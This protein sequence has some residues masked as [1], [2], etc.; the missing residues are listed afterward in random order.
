[1]FPDIKI[2]D[3]VGDPISTAGVDLSHPSSLLNYLKTELLHLAVLPDFL[4][5]KDLKLTDAATK[6]IEFKADVKD[7]FQLGNTKPE[8]NVTPEVQASIRVNATPGSELVEDDPF[9]LG[10]KVPDKTGYVSVGFD[11]S[12]DLGVSGSSGDLTFGLDANTDVRLE[13]FKAFALGAGEPTL[14]DAVVQTMSTYVIPA[15][16]SDITSLGV[17]DIATVSGSGSLKFSG[18]VLVNAIPNPLVSVD[19]PLGAGSIAVQAGVLAGLSASFTISGN[20]QVHALRLDPDTI[21]LSFLRERGTAWKADLSSSAG[22]SATIGSL[23]LINLLIGAVSTDPMHDKKQLALLQPEEIE[24]LAA[25]IKSGLNHNL[26]ASLDLVLSPSTDNQVGFQYYVQPAKLSADANQ[27]VHRAL[28]GDLS[29]LTTMEDTMQE[30]GVL[31]P[32][33]QLR[34][35]LLTELRKHDTT[36]K[37]NLLGIVNLVNVSDL[38]LKGETL[39]DDVTGDVTIKE[40]VTGNRISA[41]TSP[42][43]RNEALRKAIFDSVLATTSYRA[44][45]AI[46]APTLTC[47]QVHFALNQK[48]NQQIMGDYLNWFCALRLLTQ[49]DK[50]ASLAQ[51]G[52]GG[53]STCVLRTS[54]AD[55]DCTA[56]FFDASGN[57]RPQSDFLEIG[58]QAMR[59]LLN[60][61]QQDIDK[62][63]YQIVDDA[64]WPQARKMGPSRNLGSLVGLDPD[65]PRVGVLVGD[66]LVITNWADAMSLVGSAVR[67]VRTFVGNADPAT[68]AQNNVFKQKCAAMQ[69]KLSETVKASTMR[70]EEPWGMVCL[71]WAAGSPSS[72]YA[73]IS[74]A[75]LN[76]ERGTQPKVLADPHS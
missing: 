56:M 73:K 12:L 76:L 22:L 61:A 49:A 20:Y 4:A 63:R 48:T 60:P 11:G 15:D 51:F 66:V 39:T 45:K 57:L 35:S 24:A 9:H 62:L 68:L 74:S 3:N 54:F 67:D 25:A 37:L 21:E 16:I 26:A 43:D 33:L 65:D 64:L 59:A 1:M 40:T 13:Y 5:R 71:Y 69:G 27:A 10:A 2:T 7:G 53:A 19:L 14:A 30:G 28:D 52:V 29:L 18:G 58:R 34:Q 32:G 47:Q 75:S 55:G 50:A 38:I 70:F 36:L 42:L 8:I 44:G 23:D 31:A 46:A 72:S 41:I 6:P 17:N